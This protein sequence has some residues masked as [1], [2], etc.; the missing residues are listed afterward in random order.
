MA[1]SR[2]ERQELLEK[3][4][5]FSALNKKEVGRLAAI[6]AERRVPSG[7]VLTEEGQP[8]DEFFVVA[9]GMAQASIGGRKVGSIPAGSF[10]G[11]L[12]LLDRGP[13]T[14]TVTAELPT[15][16]V[17]LTSKDFGTVLEDVPSISLKIMRGLASRIRQ[18]DQDWG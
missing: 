17:V 8:G 18:A 4:S 6:S 12:S 2:K 16:L 5:M 9:E 10:F 7:T 3:V 14:A 1:G 13:R 15:R 11:E